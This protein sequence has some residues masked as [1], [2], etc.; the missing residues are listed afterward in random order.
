MVALVV[1]IIVWDKYY[2]KEKDKKEEKTVALKTSPPPT[3][4]QDP[5]GAL[6]SPGTGGGAAPPVGGL[7]TP[8]SDMTPPTGPGETGLGGTSS[9][10]GTDPFGGSGRNVRKPGDPFG[11]SGRDVRKPPSGDPFGGSGRDA[12]KPP[13]SDPFGGSGRDVRRPPSSDPFG[14][15]E[16]REISRPPSDSEKPASSGGRIYKVKEGDTLWEIAE[17]EYKDGTKYAKIEEA[18]KDKLGKG[19]LLKKGMELVLPDLAAE[20]SGG[21]KGGAGGGETA[22]P[23]KADEYKVKSGDNLASIAKERLGSEAHWTLIAEANKETLKG[24]P[25]DLKVGTVL[26]IPPKPEPKALEKKTD[27]KKPELKEESIPPEF[28]G[29]RTYRIKSGDSLWTIAE[30]ELG[31][32]LKWEKIFEANKGRVKSKNDLTVGQVIVLPENGA[33]EAPRDRAREDRR[34]TESPR[35]DRRSP[36]SAEPRDFNPFVR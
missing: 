17:K 14:V 6:T 34:R 27:G 36:A 24:K 35:D 7:E 32:G 13:S 15:Q 4:S 21:R 10:A 9:G 5:F 26:R 18:N 1:G 2:N 31:S 8:P 11:G 16:P 22:E 23:L 28:A 12:R 3:D 30:K 19:A 29:K 20:K 33:A 25:N